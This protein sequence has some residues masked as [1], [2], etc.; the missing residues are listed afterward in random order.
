MTAGVASLLKFSKEHN[1]TV[2][3]QRLFSSQQSQPGLLLVNVKEEP[4]VGKTKCSEYE[5]ER[6]NNEGNQILIK[7]VEILSSSEEDADETSPGEITREANGSGC[8]DIDVSLNNQ[9]FRQYPIAPAPP[10][11]QGTYICNFNLTCL[12][13]GLEQVFSILLLALTFITLY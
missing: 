4:N 6:R 7:V 10:N 11:T 3:D 12:Y 2:E 1:I 8:L 9:D 13:I 5:E